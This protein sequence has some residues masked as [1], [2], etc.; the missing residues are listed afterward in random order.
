M[1]NE[2]P[3]ESFCQI[4]LTDTPLDRMQNIVSCLLEILNLANYVMIY[5]NL[6]SSSKPYT[7]G[8]IKLKLAAFWLTLHALA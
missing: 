5:N 7:V 1:I 2:K 8:G 4:Y 6:I 3:T